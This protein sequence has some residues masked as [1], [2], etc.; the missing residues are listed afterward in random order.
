MAKGHIYGCRKPGK[1]PC[2]KK[3]YRPV[4]FDQMYVYIVGK[5]GKCQTNLADI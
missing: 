3:N 2:N 1:D 5:N 4:F